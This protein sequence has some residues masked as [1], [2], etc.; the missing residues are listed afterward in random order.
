MNIK[1][2]KLNS[3]TQKVVIDGHAVILTD[4][5][6]K[7]KFEKR[8]KD[9]E[10]KLCVILMIFVLLLMWGAIVF[11]AFFKTDGYYVPDYMDKEGVLYDMDGDGDYYHWVEHE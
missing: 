7:A 8:K 6:K 10:S 1:I 2:Q 3:Y 5:D 9:T 11:D 4:T